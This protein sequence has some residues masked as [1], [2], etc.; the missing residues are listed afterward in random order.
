MA[1][2]GAAFLR[3]AA[4]KIVRAPPRPLVQEG[5]HHHGRRLL[6]WGPS[7]RLS[8]YST[9]GAS[10]PP[11]T[12]HRVRQLYTSRRW[13]SISR[14]FYLVVLQIQFFSCFNHVPYLRTLSWTT[15]Y[16]ILSE[17]WIQTFVHLNFGQIDFGS[18]RHRIGVHLSHLEKKGKTFVLYKS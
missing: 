11:P 8:S 4:S 17:D 7:Y 2:A 13:S 9:S 15:F 18:V 16:L 6:G 12:N 1:G 5:L 10:K 14:H 3:S